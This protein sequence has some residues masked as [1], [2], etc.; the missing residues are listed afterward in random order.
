MTLRLTPDEPGQF[1][2][3]ILSRGLARL[4]AAAGLPAMSPHKSGAGAVYPFATM[5]LNLSDQATEQPSCSGTRHGHAV[6]GLMHARDMADLKAVSQNLMH[7]NVGVTDGIYA[8]LSDQ[9]RRER[10]R[11]LGSEQGKGSELGD[12]IGQLEM[13]LARLKA[14][15]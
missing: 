14:K 4:F 10:I 3:K 1:R 2:A 7:G 11:G 13:L 5:D 6:Y 15:A 9:D 12:V 8:I